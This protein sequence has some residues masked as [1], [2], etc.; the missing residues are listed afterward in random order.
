MSEISGSVREQSTG[1]REVAQTANRMDQMT[2]QN[3]AMVEESTAASHVM[4]QEAQQLGELIR[5]FRIEPGQAAEASG[6]RR[7]MAG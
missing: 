3:A 7:R 6:M 4:R 1:L 2:Q 5:R